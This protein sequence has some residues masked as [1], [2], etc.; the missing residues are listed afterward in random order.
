MAAYKT[1]YQTFVSDWTKLQTWAKG[2]NIPHAALIPVFQMDRTRLLNGEY[3]MG[4]GERYRAVLAS[5]GLNYSTSL[6]TD[7]PSPTNIL[8]NTQHNLWQIFTGLNPVGIVENTFSTVKNTLEHPA[9]T[10]G[11]LTTKS[12]MAEIAEHPTK[13]LISWV[14]GYSDA[15]TLLTQKTG[16]KELA[17]NPVSS[18]LNVLPIGKAADLALT[19]ETG[20]RIAARIGEPLESLKDVQ[21]L[22]GMRALTKLAGTT[23]L[24]GSTAMAIGKDESGQMAYGSATVNDMITK[25]M[26]NHG[27]GKD[28]GNLMYGSLK[29]GQAKTALAENILSPLNDA[30]Q[31]L[32]LPQRQLMMT[33][34]T[35]SGRSVDDLTNDDSLSI[36]LKE[37]ISKYAP[38][39]DWLNE[40]V[41]DSGEIGTVLMPDSGKVEVYPK[42]M[43]PGIT[44]Q[45]D[46]V[47]KS[48][49]DLHEPSE[50]AMN[51]SRQ[52]DVLDTTANRNIDQMMRLK[53]TV[54]TYATGDDEN[55]ILTPDQRIQDTLNDKDQSANPSK[56]HRLVQSEDHRFDDP[57][58][59]RLY[60]IPEDQPMFVRGKREAV[61]SNV[62]IINDIAKP[63]GLIDKIQQA[64]TNKDF[65]TARKLSLTASRRLTGKFAMEINFNNPSLGN[66]MGALRDLT[67]DTY[68][69]S[70]NRVKLERDFQDIYYGRTQKNRTKSIPYLVSEYNKVNKQYQDYIEK[71]PPPVMQPLLNKLYTQKILEHDNAS[72][73][74]A[75]AAKELANHNYSQ[76]EIESLLKNPQV[77][78]EM[79]DQFSGTVYNDPAV[80]DSWK[81]MAAS[82]KS[83]AQKSVARIRA[84]GNDLE[85]HYVPQITASRIA[86]PGFDTYNVYVNTNKVPTTQQAFSRTWNFGTSTYNFMA[87]T[88][89]AVKDQLS[90]EGTIEWHRDYVMPLAYNESDIMK[91]IHS[92]FKDRYLNMDLGS[93]TATS[94]T[95]SILK[96]LGL[97]RYNPDELFTFKIPRMTGKE[98]QM[99]LPK[100]IAD[101]IDKISTH[102]QFPAEGA[103][104]KATKLFRFSIL[105]LSPRF[106]AHVAVG[107]SY[108]MLLRDTPVRLLRVLPDAYRM[109][110]DG[111]LPEEIMNNLTQEGS[112]DIALQHMG[113]KTASR[114]AMEQQLQKWHL[115]PKAAP[116]AAWLKAAANVNFKFTRAVGNM[117]RA[118]TFLSGATKAEKLGY[119]IDENGKRILNVSSDRAVH[120]GMQAVE[121]VFGDTRRMSPFELS[122]LTTIFPF[123]SW[124]KHILKY[125]LSYPVDHPMRAMV[126]AGMAENNTRNVPTGLPMRMQLLLML[127]SPSPTGTVSALTVRFM[128]PLRTNANYA[129]LSGWLSGVNP[130][131]SGIP[132]MIDPNIT[133][134]TNTL[135][136]TKSYN[137]VFGTTQA[138]PSGNFLNY[139]DGIV[140]EASALQEAL[141]IGQQYRNLRKSTP[142]QFKKDIFES[143]NVPFL[144]V[145]HLNLRAISA[146][147]QDDR[148]DQALAAAQ[149]AIQSGTFAS[150]K[151]YGTVPDPLNDV[152]NVS[153]AMLQSMYENSVSSTGLSP[154]ETTAG[155]KS[156]NLL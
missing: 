105:G 116:M 73:I 25:F 51:I 40:H 89:K 148:Y 103:L 127:G 117:Q 80:G 58:V 100:S 113:G 45:V 39:K 17:D 10:L 43:L 126:L 47:N 110:K 2:Q 128:D 131:I 137:D 91:M 97:V 70:K 145:Q 152:Y 94:V 1:S 24:P 16:L 18:L 3:P 115:T 138:N 31:L 136:P 151:G 87:A 53:Q 38:L 6:P 9:T 111:T 50:R 132:A 134:G 26:R 83:D 15:A 22:A 121:K 101:T 82:V 64:Y 7:N 65:D 99:F 125:T 55:A 78:F 74:M 48:L 61:K 36:P 37:A 129:S 139:V 12:K 23:K 84:Q 33:L 72:D 52:T 75:G 46:K 4:E 90:K 76:E 5:A 30:M 106:T 62:N 154:A 149:T 95:N 66:V 86:T 14:P 71:N 81:A 42:N 108:L 153:P 150:L 67:S 77:M 49:Q 60:N 63:G 118:A 155:P 69:I 56:I 109:S 79:I 120:M 57:Q 35:T 27:I 59:R 143:L 112:P 144:N 141:G 68:E 133:F 156:P 34:L 11:A 28:A 122:V 146:K 93:N 29:T 44:R 107:G 135:Y 140:P 130:V 102:S 41:L 96:E 8:G 119:I 104:N 19:G 147:D 98:D 114:W 88:T 20:A 54:W 85:F 124:T 123:W 92:T 21:G 13:S 32:T 142:A